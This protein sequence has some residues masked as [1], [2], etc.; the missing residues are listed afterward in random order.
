VANNRGWT[1][2]DEDCSSEHSEAQER[3]A[4][5]LAQEWSRLSNEIESR[6]FEIQYQIE[7]Q[8][9]YGPEPDDCSQCVDG[10]MLV[11]GPVGP[12]GRLIIPEWAVGIRCIFCGG[13]GMDHSWEKEQDIRSEQRRLQLSG[14]EA[15]LSAVGARM[16]R[17]YEH[18]NEDERFMEYSERD[19]G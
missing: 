1:W 4:T 5:R 10:I 12:R 3:E 9:H 8:G 2:L 17:P 19:R 18:W 11:S 6:S 13:D 14:L 15:A 16:M 7:E